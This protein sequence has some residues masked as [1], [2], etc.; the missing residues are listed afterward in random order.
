ME[1]WLNDRLVHGPA[2]RIDPTD[3]GFALG[4]GLFETLRVSDGAVEYAAA[5]LAR[6]RKGCAILKF[7]RIDVE[8]LNEAMARVI[9]ANDMDAGVLRLTL[10]RGAAPRGMAPPWEPHPTVL[11]APAA[12]PESA[13]KPVTAVIAR[14]TRRN[15]FSPLSAV[16]SLNCGDNIVARIEARD[17][18]ADDALMPN[19]TGTIAC[20]TSAN[21]FLVVDGKVVTPPVSDGAL[22]GV[23]RGLLFGPLA[24][25]EMPITEAMLMRADEVFLSN[26]LSI[27][28]VLS[29]DDRPV[30]SGVPGPVT[31]KASSRPSTRR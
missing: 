16:K 4:D 11:I 9:A 28:A 21:V 14:G 30:G 31:R 2:A 3:R 8:G 29:I 27:R 15:A 23:M 20:A 10:T 24:A 13:D 6:L 22:P 1:V 25:E 17:R 19:G 12:L 26:S 7:P 5:H 18:G